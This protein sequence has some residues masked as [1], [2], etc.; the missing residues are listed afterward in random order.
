MENQF[1]QDFESFINE[2][3]I[4]ENSTPNSD[5]E[6]FNS[7]FAKEIKKFNGNQIDQ[8]TSISKE[9][10]KDQIFSVWENDHDGRPIN[11]LAIYYAKSEKHAL[12]KAAINFN[13]IETF[14]TGYYSAQ[15]INQSKIKDK[16]QDLETELAIYKNIK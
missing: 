5:V 4:L 10:G 8:L 1:I 6:N 3:L 13:T 15:N 11:I 9:K 7:K 14:T 16:I 2:S 12:I